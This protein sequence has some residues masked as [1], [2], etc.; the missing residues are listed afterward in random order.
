MAWETHT[1]YSLS[2]ARPDRINSDLLDTSEQFINSFMFIGCKSK[3]SEATLQT[4][5]VSLALK[6]NTCRSMVPGKGTHSN[7]LGQYEL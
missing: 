3:H 4:L 1:P 7:L 5:K 2:G 6:P